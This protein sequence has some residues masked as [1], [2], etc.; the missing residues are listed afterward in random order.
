MQHRAPALRRGLQAQQRQAVVLQPAGRAALV[1]GPLLPQLLRLLRPHRCLQAGAQARHRLLQRA[2]LSG[3]LGAA[4]VPVG[5]PIRVFVGALCLRPACRGQQ[6]P[7]LL[8]QGSGLGLCRGL[9]RCH[10]LHVPLHLLPPQVGLPPRRVR[11]RHPASA[12][13]PPAACRE[14]PPPSCCGRR[15]CRGTPPL[16]PACVAMPLRRAASEA[17]RRWQR[18]AGKSSGGSRRLPSL[19]ARHLDAQTWCAIMRGAIASSLG[20]R[21]LLC[22]APCMCGPAAA[23]GPNRPSAALP[24]HTRHCRQVTSLLPCCPAGKRS[25][26][27][28][29]LPE[30]SSQHPTTQ[31]TRGAARRW[32]MQAAAPHHR[33]SRR[34]RSVL[35]PPPPLL[36]PPPFCR[37]AMSLPYHDLAV[38]CTLLEANTQVG[39]R[40]GLPRPLRPRSCRRVPAPAAAACHPAPQPSAH[41][42]LLPT[43]R[44]RVPR[45]QVGVG[46]GGP[47]AP[48]HSQADRG[49]GQARRCRCPALAG[50]RCGAPACAHAACTVV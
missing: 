48:G 35:P 8:R 50:R 15:G 45:H 12:P 29:A 22:P 20:G 9:P 10:C 32:A 17:P 16:W 38:S 13:P 41:V 49:A 18:A 37:P 31:R 33:R 23:A 28:L 5:W 43:A 4:A 36:G 14:R 26:P 42:A 25:A 21:R 44:A 46:R 3:L 6:L 30:A 34:R 7:L 24:V 19:P 27:K 11:G 2:A 47:G 40:S 39:C 1:R